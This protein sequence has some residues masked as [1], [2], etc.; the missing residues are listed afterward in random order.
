M[1]IYFTTKLWKPYVPNQ[2]D[3]VAV[4]NT[5]SIFFVVQFVVLTG[6]FKPVFAETACVYVASS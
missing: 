5:P 4:S 1:Q 2:T 3:P 6:N